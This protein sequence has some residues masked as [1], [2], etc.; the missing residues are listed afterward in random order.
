MDAPSAVPLAHLLA[1]RRQVAKYMRLAGLT[2]ERL[3]R[4]HWLATDGAFV[5]VC[6]AWPNPDRDLRSAERG[7]ILGRWYSEQHPDGETAHIHCI[8]CLPIS[9]STA[10][11]CIAAWKRRQ[12]SHKEE[13]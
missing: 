5:A 6:Q 13:A 12:T 1:Q 2:P 9:K 3:Q 8:H 4:G 7:Y 10:A 11:D